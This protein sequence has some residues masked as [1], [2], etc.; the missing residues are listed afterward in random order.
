MVWLL[1][2]NLWHIIS[3][4][5]ICKICGQAKGYQKG[6]TSTY[7][8]R[9]STNTFYVDSLSITLGNPRKH[10]WTYAI[11]HSYDANYPNNNCPCSIYPGPN[12]PSFDGDHYYCELV[13]QVLLVLLH[14][15][16]TDHYGM[17]MT[18]ITAVLIPSCLGSFD[19]FHY[20]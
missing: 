13:I 9:S 3:P 17:D 20:L 16:H 11:G 15:I 8:T 14:I 12:P 18:A 6:L 7:I 1:L 4:S 19:N 5:T 10:V 2:Y